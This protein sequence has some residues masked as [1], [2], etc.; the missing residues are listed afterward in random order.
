MTW[1]LRTIKNTAI[2][3]L[4][5]IVLI[6]ATAHADLVEMGYLLSVD[7]LQRLSSEDRQRVID[8]MKADIKDLPMARAR[9]PEP[10]DDL[11]PTLENLYRMYS[12]FRDFCHQEFTRWAEDSNNR[13]CERSVYLSMELNLKTFKEFD[14]REWRGEWWEITAP[15][16]YEF[17]RSF[18]DKDGEPHIWS[19]IAWYTN[20][21][22]AGLGWRTLEGYVC[23]EN[24]PLVL[25]TEPEHGSEVVDLMPKQSPI[26]I[27]NYLPYMDW[28]YVQYGEQRGYAHTSFICMG[29]A[30]EPVFNPSQPIADYSRHLPD[31]YNYVPGSKCDHREFSRNYIGPNNG[32][33]RL[34][35]NVCNEAEGTTPRF[36]MDM[37]CPNQAS[38]E[39]AAFR[40]LYGDDVPHQLLPDAQQFG[41]GIELV[42]LVTRMEKEGLCVDR[43]NN[44]HRPKSYN[45][46]PT[47][48]GKPSSM[49]MKEGGAKA[50]DILFCNHEDKRKAFDLMN[51]WHNGYFRGGLGVYRNTPTLH[52]DLRGYAARW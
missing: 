9:M 24:D 19:Y 49:H 16:I 39:S 1:L 13:V 11:A 26:I 43:I 46:H 2:A 17:I 41:T 23:T 14:V 10:T 42:R 38:G 33:R 5:A 25:R 22:G 21:P 51:D 20:V 3:G 31:F 28:T 12:N 27:H 37:T 8:S 15:S 18:G 29:N 34:W 47:V 44:W 36:C 7:E 35:L 52:I 45:N 30:R 32:D 4:S 48:G 40:Q 6:S 50:I